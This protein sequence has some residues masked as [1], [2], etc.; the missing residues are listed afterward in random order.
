MTEYNFVSILNIMNGDDKIIKN[1]MIKPLMIQGLISFLIPL[2]LLQVSQC[3]WD[4]VFQ[5]TSNVSNPNPIL[6]HW[7][8]NFDLPKGQSDFEDW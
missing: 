5:C 2:L 6:E 4:D 7:L 1:E 8:R 3:L